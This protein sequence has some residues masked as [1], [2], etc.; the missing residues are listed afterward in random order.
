MIKSTPPDVDGA[1]SRH[2]RTSASYRMDRLRIRHVRL[3]EI[4][5]RRGSLGA[6]AKELALSQP[7][8]TL[9]LRELEAVFGASLVDRDVRGGRLTAAGLRALER[10]NAA[11][12]GLEHAISS[13]RSAELEPPLR[14][15]CAQ[16]VG[17]SVLPMAIAYLGQDARVMSMKIVEGE[18]VALLKELVAGRLDCVVAWMDES[19]SAQHS[20]DLFDIT[21][22]WKGRMQVVAAVDHPLARVRNVSIQALIAATWL[23][24]RPGSRTFAAFLRLFVQNGFAPPPV[25]VESASVHTA[26]NIVA[27]TAMLTVTPDTVA[28]HYARQGKIAILQGKAIDLGDTHASLIC[29]RENR[30]LSALVRLK[31]ALLETVEIGSGQPVT[32]RR[33]RP[34]VLGKPSRVK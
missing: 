21:P 11:L 17:I 23:M 28:G 34:R 13:S 32:A 1:L 14:L 8:V 2:P 33:R 12:S 5:H 18:A 6:A 19:V 25:T 3:L 9:M 26:M 4:I 22:L 16:V 30:D 10:L 20:L 7:A 24:P 27:A 31:D 15:G 29:L